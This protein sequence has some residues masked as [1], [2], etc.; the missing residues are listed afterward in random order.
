MGEQR[1][2]AHDMW[3]VVRYID[4]VI[5]DGARRHEW[6]WEREWRLPDRLAFTAS[7]VAFLSRLRATMIVCSPL[8]VRR[9]S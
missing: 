8:S 5:R 3:R 2:W 4:P 7:D 6:D 9:M 1:A